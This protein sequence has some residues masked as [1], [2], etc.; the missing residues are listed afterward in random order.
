MDGNLLDIESI[1]PGRLGLQQRVLPAYRGPLFD[2]LA[3]RCQVGLGVFAGK[4]HPQEFILAAENLKI[5]RYFPA[6]NLHF[7]QVN[8]RFYLLWQVNFLNWLRSWNPDGLI[9]EA[10]PRYLSTWL[11][12]GWMHQRRRPVIGWGVGAPKSPSSSALSWAGSVV[13]TRARR[14]LLHSLDTLVASRR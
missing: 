6:R 13:Q 1:F 5:A 14:S 12:I 8:S 3:E 10:N 7:L 11:A 9:V 2:K 4:G